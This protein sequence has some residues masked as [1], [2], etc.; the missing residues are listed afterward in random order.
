MVHIF[1]LTCWNLILCQIVMFFFVFLI[2]NYDQILCKHQYFDEK[3]H[4]L[5]DN[6][7]ENMDLYFGTYGPYLL[8][9]HS[10]GL[11]QNQTVFG[12]V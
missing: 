1:T 3:R 4:I 8:S 12:T 9:S 7:V 5:T 10:V 6:E 2:V 11:C